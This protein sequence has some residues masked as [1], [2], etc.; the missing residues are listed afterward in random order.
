MPTRSGG[1][2]RA[3]WRAAYARR[4]YLLYAIIIVVMLGYGCSLVTDQLV[5][6]YEA[7]TPRDAE[8]YLADGGPIYLGPADAP[9]AVLML[10][11]FSGTP[12]AFHTLPEQIAAAGWRVEAPLLPGHGTSPRAMERTGA[13][14]YID[15]AAEAY[16]ALR[17]RYET[18][19]V[20]GHSMGGALATIVVAD[21]YTAPPEGAGEGDAA[22]D[23]RVPLPPDGLILPAPY[24]RVTHRWY[25]G[26]RPEQYMKMGSTALRWV[27]GWREPVARPEVD[28][29]VS[30]S[31]IPAAS[32]FPATELARRARQ[33]EVLGAIACPTLVLHSVN[34]RVTSYRAARAAFGH[35]GTEDREFISLERSNHILFWDYEREAVSEAILAFLAEVAAL[36]SAAL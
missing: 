32:I 11:G 19:V 14:A 20:L 2:W 1:G 33:P 28:E 10:H 9:R 3:W 34:D 24:Y 21:T 26:L 29:V 8:G 12:D 5:S 36:E 13:Q 15:F 31:W 30:Y 22:A 7:S 27:P 23:N 4:P 17:A 18:L 6:R 25:Y 16:A 35:L